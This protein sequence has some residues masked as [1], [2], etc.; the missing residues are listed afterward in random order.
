VPPHASFFAQGAAQAIGD[1]AALS[2]ALLASPKDL[3]SSLKKYE[4]ARRDHTAQIQRL[5]WGNNVASHLPDGPEQQQRDAFL[6]ASSG[7]DGLA[8]LYGN[9]PFAIPD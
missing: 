5:S 4:H 1:A 2:Q 8:W 9:D 6:E 7:S 3:A